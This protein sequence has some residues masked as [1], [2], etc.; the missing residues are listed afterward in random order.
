M[1]NFVDDKY[2]QVFY[3]PKFHFEL[4]HIEHFWS[5]CRG[6][7]RHHCEYFLEKLQKEGTRSISQVDNA[8]ILA[9]Y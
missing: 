5:N 3:Y 8:T 9:N 1:K 7:S 2:H 6:Y 4:D